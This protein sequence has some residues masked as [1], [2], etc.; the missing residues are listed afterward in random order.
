MVNDGSSWCVVCQWAVSDKGLR[1]I[2][3]LMRV[4]LMRVNGSMI[5][6]WHEGSMRNDWW[7]VIGDG[8]LLDVSEW[9]G[10]SDNWSWCWIDL[11]WRVDGFWCN[12]FSWLSGV[13]WSWEYFGW[14]SS[15]KLCRSWSNKFSNSFAC[16]LCYD[17]VKS[18]DSV[19]GLIKGKDLNPT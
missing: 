6:R 19:R 17:S 4:R 11:G 15:D 14:C 8:R 1:L 2:V 12:V 13:D 9:M 18:V 3:R 7:L 16:G 10:S 5:G